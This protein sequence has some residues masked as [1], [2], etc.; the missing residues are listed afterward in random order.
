MLTD[1]L[2]P[3]WAIPLLA[4]A[5]IEFKE[6]LGYEMIAFAVYAAVVSAFFFWMPFY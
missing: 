6:I 4:A 1:L 3:F 5:G 2:Q